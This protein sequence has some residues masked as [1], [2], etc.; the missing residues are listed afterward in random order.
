MKLGRYDAGDGPRIGVIQ[1]DGVRDAGLDLFQP[2]LNG[3]TFHRLADVALLAP[4]PSPGKVICVGLNYRDH[5]AES[6][7]EIPESPVLFAKFANAVVGPG[8]PIVVPS[9]SS[10][11]D[12]EAELGVVIGR[13]ARSVSVDHALDYVLGYTCINDVSA[14]DLQFGDGQWFRGKSLDTFCPIGPWIVTPE[15]IPDPQSLGIRCIVNGQTL[16]D[17][18]TSQMAFS[19]AELVSFISQG[20]TL[21]RGDIIST[22]TPP[23]VGFARTPPIWLRPG[24]E[25]TVQ[26]DAI[27]DLTN[28]VVSAHAGPAA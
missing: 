22:G 9:I 24:D 21:E 18:S 26:I 20:I 27:G 11:I 2:M 15:E 12:Y 23:G 13:Q 25:V 28:P 6:R 8:D 16:Q 3:T 1:G 17:S 10:E 7:M 5:A 19:A 14:R 4:V